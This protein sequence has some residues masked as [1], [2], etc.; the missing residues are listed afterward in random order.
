MHTEKEKTISYEIFGN[1]NGKPL[2]ICHGLNSSRLE[3]KLI[4]S[5]LS[6]DDI[7]VIG[8]DRA[9]IGKSSFQKNRTILD[10]A[11]DIVTIA[12]KL[13]IRKFSVMGTSAGASYAL[14][15]AYKIPNRLVSAHI[16]SGLGP[17]DENLDNL[18]KDT[19]GFISLAKKLPWAVKPI[20]WLFMGRLSQNEKKSDQFLKNI[21]QSLDEIDKDIFKDNKLKNLFVTSCREA[22]KQGANGVAQDA[23]LAYAAPWGFKLEDIEFQNIYFYNGE[24]DLSIPISMGKM[25]S[26]AIANSKLK[27]YPNDGH[28]SILANQMSEIEKDLFT[29]S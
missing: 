25:M 9:G 19:K 6:S 17:I 12:N 15:C 20:F 3:A 7:K 11:D 21:I 24:L 27:I 22:Y 1:P 14:A 29:G 4:E 2:F 23:L 13:G 16:V 18:S 28:L 8:I 26:N 5:L 10:F